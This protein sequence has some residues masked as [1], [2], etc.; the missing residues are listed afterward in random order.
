MTD[1]VFTMVKSWDS[2]LELKN[3]KFYV[4]LAKQGQPNNFV[5]FRPKKAYLRV[6]VRL[7]RSDE[8]EAMLEESGLELMDYYS[9][10]GRY[11]IRLAKI[12]IKK[13]EQFLQEFLKLAY[14]EAAK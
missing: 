12:D 2:E 7:E 3:K 9:C 11:R 4:G 13:Q 10:W 1:A 5:V 14:D 8:I 6:G